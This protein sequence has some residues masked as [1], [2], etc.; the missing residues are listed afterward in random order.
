MNRTFYFVRHG[1]T[2]HNLKRISQDAFTVLD[3]T[4][5]KQAE[6]LGR[7]L[8]SVSFETLVCSHYVRA[9]QTAL[10]VAESSGHKPVVQEL[11]GEVRNPSVMA[12]RSY[13]DPD[14]IRIVD[15][16]F[17]HWHDPNYRYE[18]GENYFDVCERADEALRWLLSDTKGDCAV[19]THGT[20]L[21]IL[22]GTVLFEGPDPKRDLLLRK[23]MP[24]S[25]TGISIAKHDGRTW[26]FYH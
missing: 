13:Q 18:D 6:N 5:N 22:V 12:N 10:H 9:Q 25:N 17:A 8:H 4:G 24:I 2:D 14:I 3:D 20:F 16:R 19:V 26:A 11:F 15:E 1:Q 23:H 21:R 7:R